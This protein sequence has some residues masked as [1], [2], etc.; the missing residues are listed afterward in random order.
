MF[1]R[2]TKRIIVGVA[3]AGAALGVLAGCIPPGPPGGVAL[4]SN[5]AQ[6]RAA[7][8]DNGVSVIKILADIDLENCDIGAVERPDSADT[9]VTLY[10]LGHTVRQTCADNVFTQDDT[11]LLTVNDLTITGGN[12]G[13]GGAGGGIFANGPV[14]VVD[15]TIT[16]NHAG[17]GGGIGSNGLVTVV[18]SSVDGNSSGTGVGGGISTSSESPGVVLTDSTVSNNFG[19]GIGTS[20]RNANVSVRVVNSTVSGNTGAGLGGGIY[21]AGSIVLVYAT[22]VGNRAIQ[23]FD[24]IDSK[25]LESFGSV[26]AGGAS[27]PPRSNCIVHPE[28]MISHGYNFSDDDT[29][30]FTDPTDR[31]NA[32][33][34][35]VGQL[36]DNG[37]PTQTMLPTPGSPLLDWIP[38]NACRNDGAAGITT[39]QRGVRR[40]QGNACD[41]GSVEVAVSHDDDDDN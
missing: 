27:P 38:V 9:P 33:D 28:A 2:S 4:V 20:E 8:G 26:V 1:G 34:P 21:S 15:S 22:V 5:E 24:N 30:S 25:S 13:A 36:A 41:I 39:D 17:V 40:P 3:A 14:T 19:A 29:C 11:S 23:A 6:L 18:R 37:G 7:F 10:G 35:M 12:G 16:G 32:G 31:Q